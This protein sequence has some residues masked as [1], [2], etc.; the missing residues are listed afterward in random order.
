MPVRQTQD[1]VLT[2]D[3]QEESLDY[4]AYQILKESALEVQNESNLRGLALLIDCEGDNPDDMGELPREYEHRNPSGSHGLGPIIQQ[5]ALNALFHCMKPTVAFLTNKVTG[6]AIDLASFCDI[7][8]VRSDVYLCDDRIHQSRTAST[9]ITYLLPR[10]VGLSQAMRILLLG[11]TFDAKQLVAAHFAHR[12]ITIEEW[13]ESV[14][15]FCAQIGRMATRAYEVHKM[16]VL[17]QLD[18]GHDAAMVHSL[19]VRQTHLIKDRLEGIQSWRERRDP[20]FEGL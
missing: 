9:G 13:D 20:E 17:P 4:S 10:L 18:I 8:W 14:T 2:L 6:S 15:A 19:G 3:F 1:N 11:E 7:R 5:D 12:V 16:Q